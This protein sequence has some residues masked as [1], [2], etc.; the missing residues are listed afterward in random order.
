ME[1]IGRRAQGVS[2]TA[3]GQSKGQW[4]KN[5]SARLENPEI[6]EHRLEQ[7]QHL[8]DVGEWERLEALG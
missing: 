8:G 5:P 7:D 4:T 2:D 1:V 3:R 6:R